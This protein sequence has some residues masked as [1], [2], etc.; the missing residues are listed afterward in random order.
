MEKQVPEFKTVEEVKEAVLKDQRHLERA[1]VALY[2]L[3]DDTE[4][5]N[6]KASL[7][8]G[9]GFSQGH[10]KVCC[11]MAQYVQRRVKVFGHPY[12]N[13]IDGQWL[14]KA[15]KIVPQYAKQLLKLN[16]MKVQQNR[17]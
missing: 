2:E 15:R 8:D 14:V 16:K 13:N 11:F 7:K 3:N 1:L 9:K 10:M 5:A 6:K 4:R 12:G 17:V